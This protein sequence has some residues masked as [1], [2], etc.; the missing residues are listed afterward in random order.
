MVYCA[1]VVAPNG[2]DIAMISE[3]LEG[4]W[5]GLGKALDARFIFIKISHEDDGAGRALGVNFCECRC[6]LLP[7]PVLLI[8]VGHIVNLE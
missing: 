1:A 7:N 4:A 2:R 3:N 5:P 8:N 6:Q